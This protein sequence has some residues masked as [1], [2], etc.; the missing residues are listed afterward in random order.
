MADEGYRIQ[1]HY[2]QR[3]F[4][5]TERMMI[6]NIYASR[7]RP[8]A[9]GTLLQEHNIYDLDVVIVNRVKPDGTRQTIKI[10][11]DGEPS[12]RPETCSD[13]LLRRIVRSAFKAGE[14][15]EWGIEDD[16]WFHPDP[17]ADARRIA[18]AIRAARKVIRR[19]TNT[20]G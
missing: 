3:V 1:T 11:P 9:K 18:A 15:W 14:G 10:T 13:E 12:V 8:T 7:K 6:M 2:T 5:S 20:K 19:Y 16:G 4:T 17:K